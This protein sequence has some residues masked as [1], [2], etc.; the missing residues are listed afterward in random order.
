MENNHVENNQMKNEIEK[1]Q[2]QMKKLAKEFEACQKTLIALGDENRQQILITLLKNY[3]GMRVGDITEHTRLSRPAVSH[4][5]KILKEAGM[6]NMYK[7][8]T[9]NF[10]HVD[11]DKKQWEQLTELVVHSNELVKEVSKKRESGMSCP[12]SGET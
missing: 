8:G 11:A 2:K 10:Y 1:L 9:M 7:R 12:F 6:I 5:L 4:H 3:G